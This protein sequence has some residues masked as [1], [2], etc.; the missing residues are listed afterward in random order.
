MESF[1][2]PE[3]AGA[4]E[5]CLIYFCSIY[6]FAIFSWMLFLTTFDLKPEESEGKDDNDFT[7]ES[8]L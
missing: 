7:P 6:A 3:N 4:K 5:R 1:L 2:Q 8:E